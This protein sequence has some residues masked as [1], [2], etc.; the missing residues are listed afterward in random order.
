MGDARGE[1]AQIAEAL[2][3][4]ASQL[5]RVI[6]R[7]SSGQRRG[8][9]GKGAAITAV[10]PADAGG[11]TTTE[12][13][14]R[15]L[16][17]T[18]KGTAAAPQRAASSKKSRQGASSSS[19][20]QIRDQPRSD[21]LSIFDATS[22]TRDGA[23]VA[24]PPKGSPPEQQRKRS[25]ASPPA[26]PP[27]A[28]PPPAVPR[29]ASP[30][31]ADDCSDLVPCDLSLHLE[32]ALDGDRDEG[33]R[34]AVVKGSAQGLEKAGDTDAPRGDGPV[35][36]DALRTRLAVAEAKV[37][38]L[39]CAAARGAFAE[40]FVTEFTVVEVESGPAAGE[41]R[42]N[43]DRAALVAELE[44]VKAQ[45]AADAAKQKEAVAAL[46][47][48]A[49]KARAREA[50]LLRQQ[51]AQQC[52]I[53]GLKKAAR[54]DRARL[55]AAERAAT[56]PSCS[57]CGGR[58]EA[59][60]ALEEQLAEW[61][62]KG[63]QFELKDSECRRLRT[64]LNFSQ[65]KKDSD[66]LHLVEEE[67]R[68][69]NDELSSVAV[70]RTY[71][72]HMKSEMERLREVEREYQIVKKRLL[73]T[74]R[75]EQALAVSHKHSSPR[76]EGDGDGSWKGQRKPH[77]PHLGALPAPQAAVP[78]PREG[79]P[80]RGSDSHRVI[81]T[82]ERER[83]GFGA[84]RSVPVTDVESEGGSSDGAA[85]I[86]SDQDTSFST[87]CDR[88]ELWQQKQ[89][90]AKPHVKQPVGKHPN[91]LRA[92]PATA[93]AARGAAD[94]PGA[95]GDGTGKKGDRSQSFTFV[96]QA[97]PPRR[98]MGSATRQRLF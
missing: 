59:M 71:L 9:G 48:A 12:V 10:L 52:E 23:P 74:Q 77:V 86:L 65:L 17:R 68:A 69:L 92:R 45:L 78:R 19:F 29:A 50:T 6:S 47:A 2:A 16:G 38:E 14:F 58:A 95:L 62:E 11:F 89:A 3:L 4:P 64:I 90:A 56:A 5:G 22:V 53:E 94:A 1:D 67:K 60:A 82:A 44:E 87:I 31:R 57:A 8:A 75:G 32:L 20:E 80:L 21:A 15:Q 97:Q 49:E 18:G 88:I 13:G 36:T 43:A 91:P 81:S 24:R 34:G 42:G 76:G 72:T 98:R 33:S 51:A 85:G 54:K 93:T 41:E 96:P 70:Q 84:T 35:E 73:N 66:R 25:A 26:Q 40:G 37:E 39:T 63:A 7:K 46:E 30:R 28:P 61:K 27:A 83:R 79:P 55:E